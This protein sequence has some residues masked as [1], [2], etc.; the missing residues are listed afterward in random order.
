MSQ[1]DENR[2]LVGNWIGEVLNDHDLL[3]LDRHCSPEYKQHSSYAPPG[4]EGL[5]QVLNAF[6]Q[7]LPDLRARVHHVLADGEYVC[8]FITLEGTHTGHAFGGVEPSGDKL[9]V[10]SA[11][12]WRIEDSKL[13]EHWDVIDQ[14]DMMTKL[15]FLEWKREP[16]FG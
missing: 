9:A 6:I 7:A 11:D 16:Q 3:A 13:V 10:S 1:E 5:R 4:L 2:S 14:V 15:G 8:A 12:L